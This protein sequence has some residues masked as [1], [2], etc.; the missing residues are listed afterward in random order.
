M[1]DD[2]LVQACRAWGIENSRFDH[3]VARRL[4]ISP[5]DLHALELLEFHGRLTPGQLAERLQL[6]SG[7]VTALADRLE[8]HG[9][10]ERRPHPT[11]RRSSLLCLAPEAEG[12][13]MEFYEPFGE[14]MQALVARLPDRTRTEMIAF[15]REAAEVAARQAEVTRAAAPARPAS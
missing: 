15:F 12:Y 6:T 14:A 4:G 1:K 8:R 5:A 2:E 10:L 3:A 7:S 9:L 11:D 13:A